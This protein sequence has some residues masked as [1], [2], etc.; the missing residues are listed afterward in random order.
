MKRERSTTLA[1][2]QKAGRPPDLSPADW[3]GFRRGDVT[4]DAGVGI[5]EVCGLLVQPAAPRT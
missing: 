4:G 2:T 5:V 1:K 3:L